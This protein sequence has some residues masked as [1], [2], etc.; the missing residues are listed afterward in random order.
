MARP[1]F[2]PPQVLP[3]FATQ[4]RPEIRLQGRAPAAWASIRT[5]QDRAVAQF[6]RRF[7]QEAA[8]TRQ[9]ESERAAP[10]SACYPYIVSRRRKRTRWI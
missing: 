4:R 9:G 8:R 1:F 5:W 3:V 7:R 6:H 2:R 10:H